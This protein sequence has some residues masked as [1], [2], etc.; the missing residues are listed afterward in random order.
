MARPRTSGRDRRAKPIF[1]REPDGRE[2][3]DN[4]G[5]KVVDDEIA[6]VAGAFRRFLQAGRSSG[7]AGR[8]S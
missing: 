1:L 3:L 5:R 2:R 8:R 7:G 6:P 4:D